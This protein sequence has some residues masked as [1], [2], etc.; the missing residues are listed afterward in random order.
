M[1]KFSPGK[2]YSLKRLSDASGHF[3]MV[4]TDQRPSIMNLI[5]QKKGVSSYEDVASFKTLLV[6]TLQGISS[7]ILVDP[8]WGYPNVYEQLNATKGLILTLEQHQ[9]KETLKGRCS[10]N[11][12]HWSVEKIKSIGADAVKVLAWYRTD[13]DA[14]VCQHQQDYVQAIGEACK[15]YD[16]AFLFEL[17]VYPLKNDEHQTKEYIEQKGKNAQHVIE[18]VK[19]FSNPKF[20]VDIF[21]LESPVH[22]KDLPKNDPRIQALFNELGKASPVPWV[23]L[24][25]GATQKDFKTVLEYAYKAGASGYL[26]G[27]AIWIEAAQHFPNMHAMKK[28][29][30]NKACDYMHELNRLTN[31][32]ATS[33]LQHP[34]F[35]QG[36]VLETGAPKDF[37]KNYK[38]GFKDA[39]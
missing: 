17:L 38:P 36:F 23:M 32:E 27:R 31:Q 39:L 20:G 4:A 10:S 7:A 13:A 30:E 19:T 21:K 22:T 3:K 18:S 6:Q 16:I 26:A 35:E 28:A 15:K 2:Y 33:W 29:L 34:C 12:E 5:A 8:I 14:E 9:F 11:I 25:A 24:S 1:K 37:A